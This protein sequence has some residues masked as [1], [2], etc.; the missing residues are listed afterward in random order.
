MSHGQQ[1][2]RGQAEVEQGAVREAPRGRPDGLVG[3]PDQEA[4]SAA[5]SCRALPNQDATSSGNRTRSKTLTLR[6]VP[7]TGT[8][9]RKNSENDQRE[10]ARRR[11]GPRRRPRRPV[12][13]RRRPAA[14]C[15]SPGR[16]PPDPRRWRTPRRSAA[17]S[18][19]SPTRAAASGARPPVHRRSPRPPGT[20]DRRQPRLPSVAAE[21]RAEAA[22]AGVM[23]ARPSR[24]DR[25]TQ[26]AESSSATRVEA[27]TI[28]RALRP[29]PSTREAAPGR[30]P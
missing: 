1:G 25:P 23:R 9:T 5:A 6:C 19:G 4:S 11:V 30:A 28:T 14:A 7:G 16:L 29:R 3:R 8:T 2:E 15:P 18:A 17:R 12:R 24:S 21:P 13:G 27:R 26:P 10:E 20:G 22:R